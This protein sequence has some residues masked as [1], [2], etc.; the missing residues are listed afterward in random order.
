MILGGGIDSFIH[1]PRKLVIFILEIF[2]NRKNEKIMMGQ[3]D[4]ML[5]CMHAASKL[6]TC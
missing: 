6:P 3:L 1:I 4:S 5:H 2:G